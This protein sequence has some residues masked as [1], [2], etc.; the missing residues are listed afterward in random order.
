M[1]IQS[2]NESYV[3]SICIWK[4]WNNAKEEKEQKQKNNIY[5]FFILHQT[6][7]QKLVI[8]FDKYVYILNMY[9]ISI[10]IDF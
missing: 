8:S 7:L 6:R 9:S 4:Y 5:I 3:L 1:Y 2:F 10:Y